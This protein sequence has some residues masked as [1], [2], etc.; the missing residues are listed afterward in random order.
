[1]KNII[2][3]A[4]LGIISSSTTVP[5]VY[6]NYDY[7]LFN[8]YSDS[9]TY[10]F[11]AIVRSGQ[12]M[13]VELKVLKN[14]YVNNYFNVR[15]LAYDYNPG[16]GD[17]INQINYKAWKDLDERPVDRGDYINYAF[18]Y[19]AYYNYLGII[20]TRLTDVSIK[21][22]LTFRVDVT[23]YYYSDI[24]DLNYN[25]DYKF[26]TSIWKD[27]KIPDGYQI[28]VRIA[29]HPDDKME[30]RLET[31]SSYNK[32][33]AFKVDVCQYKDK[34][35]ESQVYYGTDSKICKTGL[36]NES[37]EDKKYV[38]PFTTEEGINYLAIC[39]INQISALNYLYI[40]IYSE[41]GM[42]I[43][44]LVVIIV[45]PCLVVIAVVGF[46]LKKFGCIG[47]S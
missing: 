12:E 9:T 4:L 19:K 37:S 41:T 5:T 34:P 23:K 44:V 15:V 10:Y 1:M 11:R 45:I 21:D 42:A 36:S 17:I 38:Y 6:Y 32:N 31:Q 2:I 26:D 35:T 39:I 22:Y 7:N 8:Y 14:Y 46:L 33:T 20:V 47:R 24:K 27:N 29:V 18:Y 13:D 28:Y 40:Y 16:D 25:T 3:I 30:I 43:A